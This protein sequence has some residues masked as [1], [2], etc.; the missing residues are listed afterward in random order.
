MT[1]HPRL[2][3]T[4]AILVAVAAVAPPVGAAPAP[5]PA[6]M[7]AIGDSLSLGFGACA[8]FVPCPDVSW[9]TGAGTDHPGFASHYTR[10]AALESAL[11]GN[12]GNVAVPG[13]SVSAIPSQVA[14]LA[15]MAPEY[16]TILIGAADVCKP[17]VDLM[18]PVD[19]FRASF[20]NG[21]AELR[22]QIPEA[23][24]LAVGIPDLV[25]VL[26]AVRG[27]TGIE[28]G[29]FASYCATVYANPYSDAKAD[30]QRRDLVRGRIRRYNDAIAAECAR[31]GLCRTDRGALFR[32]RWTDS[33]VSADFLHPSVAGQQMMA[34]VTFAA[35]W[36]WAG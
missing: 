8:N 10:L 5:P 19:T 26:H 16:V 31:D 36:R 2:L 35:G 23:R 33:E 9:S 27:R 24:V 21:L 29:F 1:R 20:R 28:S 22:H 6:S 12:A 25:S 32:H 30:R 14:N 11:V 15:P 18:T 13:S 3:L 4:A 34:D 17:S 7:G